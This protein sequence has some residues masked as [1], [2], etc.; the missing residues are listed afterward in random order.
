M[1]ARSE[2][3]HWRMK[4]DPMKPAPPVTRMESSML[5]MQLRA[6]TPPSDSNHYSR[7]TRSRPA[8]VPGIQIRHARS[9][10]GPPLRC[11]SPFPSRELRT[12]GARPRGSIP[13]SAFLAQNLLVR[14]DARS[15]TIDGR[16]GRAPEF[17]SGNRGSA[18]R[19]CFGRGRGRDNDPALNSLSSAP[20]QHVVVSRFDRPG[21]F[22]PEILALDPFT[23]PGRSL[24]AKIGIV[25]EQAEHA[26]KICPVAATEG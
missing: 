19:R 18:G 5:R 9:A 13:P 25:D 4:F 8:S 11:Q 7:R 21:D 15:A 2:A 14:I 16:H 10:W 20:A 3:I 23:S 22:R 24:T 26:L 1:R 17:H 12:P 6:K